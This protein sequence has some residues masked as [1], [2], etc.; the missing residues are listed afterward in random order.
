MKRI[1]KYML[2]GGL[3][4]V[5]LA[6]IGI[7][8]IL[9]SRWLTAS[10]AARKRITAETARLTGGELHYEK[11]ALHLLPLPHL[12]ALQVDFQVPGKVS[13]ETDSLA[14]YPD[15]AGLV[16]GSFE[17]D[18]LVIGRPVVR[19]NL[20]P[21][22]AKPDSPPQTSP[23][24]RLPET[25]TA[26]FGAM[27]KLGPDLAV[28]VRD[29][30]VVLLRPGEPELKIDKIDMRLKSQGQVVALDLGCRSDVS[31]QM[32]FRGS[33][34][35]ETRNSQGRIK[36]DGLNARALL[37]ELPPLPGITLSDT[38]LSLDVVFSTRAAEQV[39][40]TILCKVPDV[41]I[42]RQKHR[43]ALQGVL[44]KG[45]IEAVPEK[46]TW[47]IKTLKI[48]SQGLDLGSSGTLTF[49]SRAKPATLALDAVG[50]RI[51]VAAV[52]RSFTDFAGDQAWVPTA[53]NVAREGRLTKATCHLV[54]RKTDGK[55]TVADLKAAG[56]LDA[57]LITI[58][59]ADLDLKAVSG[60]VVLD[61][62][63]V[64]FKQ[65][66]GRLHF[67][68]FDKLDARIDWHQ[69][70]TLGISTSRGTLALE[71]FY[72]WLTAFEGLQDMRKFI[73]TADGDLNLTRLVL[74]GPLTT[75]AA[76]KIEVA[77]GVENVN[78]TSPELNGPL[79]I[80]QGAVSFKPRTFIYEKVHLKYLDADVI[81]S[82]ITIGNPGHPERVG[83]SLDGTIGEQS[84]AWIRRFKDLPE[85]FRVKP[86]VTI[87]GMS[88]HWDDR[89][90]VTLVG[91]LSTAGGT[92][93]ITDAAFAPGRWQINRF[94]L[95]DGI[96]NVT[97]KFTQSDEQV[98]LDYSGKLHRTT[99]DRFLKENT[100]LKGW[101][102]GKLKASLD[103]RDLRSSQISGALR[104]EGLI[105]RRLPVSPIEFE[106]FSLECLGK[107]AR[108]ESADLVFAGTPMRLEGTAGISD[109]AYTFDLDLMADS[110]DAAALS[111]VQKEQPPGAEKPGPQ[112]KEELP[113]DGVIR[114]KTPRFTFKDYAWS[115]VHADIT[116]QPET[117]KVAVTRSDLCGISTPGTVTVKPDG[118]HLTFKPVAVKKDLQT[119]WEC[120][121]SKPLQADSVYTLIGTV[122]ASGPAGD[123]VKNLQ[124]DI[125]FSSDDG[126]I[127]RSNML[128]KIFSFLNLTE[129]FAGK[130]SGM[131]DKGFGYDAIRA[132]AAIKAGALNFDEI[133]VDGHAMKIS[134]EG[135]VNL[136]DEK[137]DVTLLVAPLK[138]LDRLVKNMPVVGYITGG[139]I[140]SV[141]V[142]IK[143]TTADPKVV[144][145]PPAA[146]GRGIAG[147]LERTLK[148]PLK[149]VESLPRSDPETALPDDHTENTGPPSK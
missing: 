43:L 38:R 77:S 98:S 16:S 49:G 136:V 104:G 5:I 142:G 69:A 58:P 30:A 145:L 75:P 113:I 27:A 60:K 111:K 46:L 41:K 34:N 50:R 15:L 4:I 88:L 124:G 127:Y 107:S 66:H 53:F 31:G 128:T 126:M 114:F 20:T 130:V 67:G 24:K 45:D 55:W 52:A 119:S 2:G 149:V 82:G 148:A 6:V 147:L 93:A 110:L 17:L 25:M 23:E 134:G 146:V 33:V 62:Q 14:I 84:L 39:K 91:E 133:L 76:W 120:L 8:L 141:P 42:R 78:I 121:Q 12:T 140:L 13:L 74:D 108:I 22:S 94:E 137:L 144:P 59:G 3:A 81:S 116:I 85:H 11:L 35:L 95:N 100:T 73:P 37:A 139:S 129:V 109:R 80:S 122:G 36:L 57:G 125:S 10:D 63:R 65:M 61:N 138:T 9:G 103:M 19:V 112:K 64:D 135:T 92:R 86:P 90:N 117:V 89:S 71:Q 32:G 97:L 143:G 118:V 26:V 102:D 70:A 1:R 47:D 83:L 96:S 29:G 131:R 99:L 123:L 28:K 56:H 44:L 51:D 18:D 101:I 132:H 87:S 105:V 48:D 72:P 54:V 7:V 68:T 21:V 40:A 106:R 79:H 115:P